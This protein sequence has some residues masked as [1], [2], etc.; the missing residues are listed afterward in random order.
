VPCFSPMAVLLLQKASLN[1]SD[2]V[3]SPLTTN[4]PSRPHRTTPTM[5]DPL[6]GLCDMGVGHA[7]LKHVLD[8]VI[9]GWIWSRWLVA[10]LT[11]ERGPAELATFGACC[12]ALRLNS[13]PMCYGTNG[14]G[15]RP[16]VLR[17]KSSGWTS[18]RCLATSLVFE[19]RVPHKARW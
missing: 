19:E 13:R 11:S 3:K 9:A 17:F 12:L 18:W 15:S 16:T 7:G 6:G 1:I 4:D 14:P 10:A 2:L 5:Q 8:V